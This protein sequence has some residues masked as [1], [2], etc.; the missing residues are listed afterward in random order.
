[1]SFGGTRD[2][3][4]QRKHGYYRWFRTVTRSLCRHKR[5]VPSGSVFGLRKYVWQSRTIPESDTLGAIMT[6]Y[7]LMSIAMRSRLECYPTMA[8]IFLEGQKGRIKTHCRQVWLAGELWQR[9]RR[10]R[11]PSAAHRIE[12]VY[13]GPTLAKQSFRPFGDSG[14][15]QTR[16]ARETCHFNVS[17]GRPRIV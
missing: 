17:I 1:M 14:F 2:S 13:P 7:S 12:V 5:S 8:R 6:V 10:R 3:K 15:K 4:C 16:P 11:Q 9:I